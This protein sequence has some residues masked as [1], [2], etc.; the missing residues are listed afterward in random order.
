[1]GELL[2]GG[3]D[4]GADVDQ[5]DEADVLRVAAAGGDERGQAGAGGPGHQGD[6]PP[7]GEHQGAGV[8]GAHQ[9]VRG[10]LAEHLGGHEDRGPGLAQDRLLRGLAH[11][12]RLVRVHDLHAAAR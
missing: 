3:V 5:Q 12:D 6:V 4:R 7:A 11:G 2:R 8:S 9:G 10:V 1:V